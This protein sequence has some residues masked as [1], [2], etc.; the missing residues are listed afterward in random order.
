MLNHVVNRFIDSQ[1]WL[2]PVADFLQKFIAWIYKR[3]GGPVVH[4]I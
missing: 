4:G 1:R 3:L 2:E